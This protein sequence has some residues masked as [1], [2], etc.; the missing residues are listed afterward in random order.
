MNITIPRLR[1]LAFHSEAAKRTHYITFSIPKKSGGERQIST[2]HRDLQICQEWILNHILEKIPVHDAVHGFVKKRNTLSN[3]QVHVKQDV[4][5]NTDLEDF[6]PSITFPR[7]RGMFEAVGYSPAVATIL[8]LLCTE[9]PR[10][11]VTYAGTIYHVAIG[12]RALP[13]GACTSPAISNHIAYRLDHRLSGIADK[14]GWKY[15]RYADDLSFSTSGESANQLAYLMARIRHIVDDEGFSV[16]E[17]KTRVQRRNSCQSVTGVVV[18]DKPNVP[19]KLRRRLRSIL[20][21]AK[22]EGLA[23][24]NRENHPNFEAWLTGMIAYISMIHPQEGTRLQNTF[25]SLKK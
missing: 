6:F 11:T 20:H 16:N 14:L 15:T 3:A 24:Q 2:P 1:W 5:I 21:H 18:N 17:K 13:Q 23:S 4:V 9:A 22:T 12:E 19:R 10:R 25:E 8:A 7:V